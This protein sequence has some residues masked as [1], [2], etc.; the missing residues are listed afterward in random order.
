[1]GFNSFDNFDSSLITTIIQSN[2]QYK[3]FFFYTICIKV[4]NLHNYAGFTI[5][6]NT[7]QTNFEKRFLNPNNMKYKYLNLECRIELVG[8]TH[9]LIDHTK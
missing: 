8:K 9:Y 7:I 2:I 3:S 6:W 5:F 1:L 4:T